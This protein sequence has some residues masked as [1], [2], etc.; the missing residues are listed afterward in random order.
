MSFLRPLSQPQPAPLPGCPFLLQQREEH[1]RPQ[2]QHVQRPWGWPLLDRRTAQ[3]QWL[4]E[5]EWRGM[6]VVSDHVEG[7]AMNLDSG[8][9][10]AESSRSIVLRVRSPE[11]GETGRVLPRRTED[12]GPPHRTVQKLCPWS[13]RTGRH[14]SFLSGERRGR[15]RQLSPS[16][17]A[18]TIDLLLIFFLFSPPA[19]SDHLLLLPPRQSFW[20][21]SPLLS[22]L[23]F[24][25]CLKPDHIKFEGEHIS[26]VFDLS[27]IDNMMSV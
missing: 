5:R 1:S 7:M 22:N 11:G 16:G 17:L 10:L 8:L 25:N 23:L 26:K 19:D 2:G 18:V 20:R 21:E 9:P 13:F 12:R 15:C 3:M 6:S 27:S 24:L 4:R 14:S